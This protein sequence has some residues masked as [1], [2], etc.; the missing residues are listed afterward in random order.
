MTEATFIPPSLDAEA[1]LGICELLTIVGTLIEACH[2]VDAAADTD[3]PA[4]VE[5][6]HVM[7]EQLVLLEVAYDAL[8]SIHERSLK[9]A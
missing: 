4:E 2:A 8:R 9:D 7:G 1:W 5:T 6:L 3:T